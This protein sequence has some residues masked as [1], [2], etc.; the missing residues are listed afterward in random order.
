M[1]VV[2]KRNALR[3]IPLIKQNIKAGSEI[4]SDEWKAYHNLNAHGY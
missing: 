1:F 4:V 3:L 2:Q